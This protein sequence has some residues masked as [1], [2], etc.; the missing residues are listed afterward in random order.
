MFAMLPENYALFG[1]LLS[2][3]IEAV[4]S[5]GGYRRFVTCSERWM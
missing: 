1:G 5:M 2:N 3:L 4:R